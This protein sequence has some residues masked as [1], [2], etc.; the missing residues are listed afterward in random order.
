MEYTTYI[1]DE[2]GTPIV[3][4]SEVDVDKYLK[5]HPEYSIKCLPIM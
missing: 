5:E 1:V 4:A 3:K 2:C